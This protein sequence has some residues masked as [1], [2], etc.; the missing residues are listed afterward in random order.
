MPLLISKSE[1]QNHIYQKMVERDA[2]CLCKK[3]GT[4]EYHLPDGDEDY[5]IY[6]VNH[7]KQ[8]ATPTSFYDCEDFWEE[9]DYHFVIDDG[10]L[11]P[12]FETVI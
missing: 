3:V 12:I 10:A 5:E 8:L 9:S 11:T 1:R 4:T 6:A 7:Q 2:F